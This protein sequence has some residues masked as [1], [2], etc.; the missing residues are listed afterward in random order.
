MSEPTIESMESVVQTPF[1]EELLKPD[2]N[3]F[4]MFQ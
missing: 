3:R 4:V 2:E 1:V